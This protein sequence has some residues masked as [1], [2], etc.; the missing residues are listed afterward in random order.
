MNRIIETIPKY[1]NEILRKNLNELTKKIELDRDYIEKISN[2]VNSD[3]DKNLLVSNEMEIIN[4]RNDFNSLNNIIKFP[5]TSKIILKNSQ[6][7]NKLIKI[8]EDHSQDILT[9]LFLSNII[10]HLTDNTINNYE[11]HSSNPKF[12][13]NILSYI[14]TRTKPNTNFEIEILDNELVTFIN[15]IK[16]D[17]KDR[18]KNNDLS[19]N[20]LKF[21]CQSNLDHPICGSNFKEILDTI[22]SINQEKDS[23]E[24]LRKDVNTF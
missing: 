1:D 12:I 5:I 19:E 20:D 23:I 11:I 17:F 13:S 16:Y 2:F 21:I 10:K 6:L 22:N 18:L 7:T 8:Y 14:L 3:L 9:N 4:V 24:R 15:L